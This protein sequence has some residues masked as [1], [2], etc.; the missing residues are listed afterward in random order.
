MQVTDAQPW[1][2]KTLYSNC[3]LLSKIWISLTI[4]LFVFLEFTSSSSQFSPL[5]STVVTY[6]TAASVKPTKSALYHPPSLALPSAVITYPTAASTT[7]PAYS[8]S[9][10]PTESSLYHSLT[11]VLSYAVITYP[12]AGYSTTLPSYSA[13]VT[14]TESPLYHSLTPVRSSA[15]ITYPKAAYTTLPSSS[16]S[17]A[18]AQSLLYLSPTSY[19]TLAM[20]TCSSSTIKPFSASP[21]PARSHHKHKRF[22]Y[23]AIATTAAVGAIVVSLVVY[24]VRKRCK[25]GRRSMLNFLQADYSQD[26]QENIDEGISIYKSP[27]ALG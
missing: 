13:S 20:V 10:S 18:H 6:P 12:T 2:I 3:V 1:A 25:K 15:V 24:I 9:V 23:W 5:P 19:A 22:P 7:L 11:P 17:V 26:I 16:A 4:L 14:P 27:K 21:H 8:A